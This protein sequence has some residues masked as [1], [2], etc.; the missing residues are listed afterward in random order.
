MVTVPTLS[1]RVERWIYD[2][3]NVANAPALGGRRYPDDTAPGNVVSPYG[4]YHM[5]SGIER[6]V[7]DGTRLWGEFV[8]AIQVIG[9]TGTWIGDFPGTSVSMEDAADQLYLALHDHAGTTGGVEIQS[10]FADEMLK[11][12]DATEGG[13][14]WR[15]LGWTFRIVAVG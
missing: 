11:R 10:C 13:T 14:R 3:L 8:Y 15:Y 7:L 4:Q 12:A 2:R 1:T 5:L 9:Q 6:S